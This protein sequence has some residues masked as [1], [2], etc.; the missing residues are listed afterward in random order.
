MITRLLT[1]SL[2]CEG[3][4]AYR[5]VLR[6]PTRTALTIGVLFMA[7]STGIG[8]GTTVIN[9]VDDVWRWYRQI[10]ASDFLVRA[11]RPIVSTGRTEK[12]PAELAV[13]IRG[14]PGVTSVDTLQLLTDIQAEGH[15]VVVVAR[16][17]DGQDVL[18]VDLA[19]GDPAE[20]QRGLRQGRVVIG[21]GLASTPI[22]R[23]A[24]KSP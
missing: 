13:Q 7:V 15:A 23:S 20:A 10:M 24:M 17:F 2:G 21:A 16:Q 12:M 8:L 11:I 14:I 1:L 9:N 5:Q 22:C 18:P 3:D 4:L 6:R 19:G